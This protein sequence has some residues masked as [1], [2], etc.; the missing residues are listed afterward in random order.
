MKKEA[1][2]SG[3]ENK[4]APTWESW[5]LISLGLREV[6]KPGIDFSLFER[7]LKPLRL[8]KAL[9]PGKPNNVEGSKILETMTPAEATSGINTRETLRL[10][11]PIENG[12]NLGNLRPEGV[13][14]S[15]QSFIASM[16]EFI[17]SSSSF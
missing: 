17:S 10:D 15:C 7:L 14:F 2:C 6:W 8:T 16:K 1:V 4:A 5:F 12:V 11:N 3:G 13:I 9:S